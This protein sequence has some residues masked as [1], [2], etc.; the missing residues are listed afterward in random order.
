[1]L[2]VWGGM[3]LG[4]NWKDIKQNLRGL[5]YLVAAAVVLAFGL[6]L[7]RHLRSR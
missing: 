4:D 7:W 3:V 5:D 2:L 6:F 1:M